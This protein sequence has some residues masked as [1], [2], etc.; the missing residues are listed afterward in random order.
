MRG[1]DGLRIRLTSLVPQSLIGPV[2]DPT[3][4]SFDRLTDDF[5]RFA[6]LVANSALAQDYLLKTFRESATLGDMDRGSAAGLV[7]S[8]G[9]LEDS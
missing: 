6:G 4:D 3:Y 2:I 7:R 8:L 5:L 9:W 1:A